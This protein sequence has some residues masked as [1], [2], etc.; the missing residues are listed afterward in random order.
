M[1]LPIIGSLIE[2]GMRI[3][4]KVIPDPQAK[5][6]AQI[7]LI[8]LQQS[9]EF[10]QMETELAMAQAQ[11]DINK[12][13]AANPSLFVSGWRPAVGWVGVAALVAAYIGAPVLT[14][15]SSIYGWPAPPKMDLSD[16]LYLLFGMMGIGTMRT[17]EKIKGVA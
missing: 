16:I 11:T 4:D 3:L 15:V 17:F 1:A 2:A 13:E 10:K 12:V 5:A 7:E 9:A 6:Q 14:W 8:K